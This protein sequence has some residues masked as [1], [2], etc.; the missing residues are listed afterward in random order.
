MRI[1]QDLWL[2]ITRRLTKDKLDKLCAL[3]LRLAHEIQ[4]KDEIIKALN[5]RDYAVIRTKH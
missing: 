4:T 3:T 5:G 1:I 2:V